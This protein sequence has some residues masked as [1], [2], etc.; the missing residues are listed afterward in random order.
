MQVCSSSLLLVHP[1]F[2][3][4]KHHIMINAGINKVFL[5]G[6]IDKEPRWH[7]HN[8]NKK[9]LHFSLLT[10][11]P[12]SKHGRT[13]NHIEVH[14]IVISD[15]IINN[16]AL[17]FTPGRLLHLEG[18]AQTRCITDA[19]NIKRYITEIYVNSFAVLI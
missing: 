13:I 18:R 11:E 9:S 1:A 2:S 4:T 14:L 19:E 8:D 3:D 5:V 6:S 10:V 7:K 15:H 17:Q 16:Q 12:I